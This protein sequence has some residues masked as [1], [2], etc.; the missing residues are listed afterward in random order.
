MTLATVYPLPTRSN[1]LL[2]GFIAAFLLAVVPEVA[3]AQY[4]S[5]QTPS[6][7]GEVAPYAMKAGKSANADQVLQLDDGSAENAIGFNDDTNNDGTSDQSLG[8]LYFNRF[9]PPAGDFP[10]ELHDVQI[11]FGVLDENG[12][13][14]PGGLS[15]GDVIDIYVWSDADGDPTTGATIEA[16]L[17][18]QALG[19]VDATFQTF[20]FPS[21]VR[22]NSPGNVLIG[23]TGRWPSKVFYPALLISPESF[24]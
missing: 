4:I 16:V 10:L 24:S 18:G 6:R 8:A 9:T 12:D 19:A 7:V 3:Q 23:S 22:I 2:V 14:D 11:Q 13:P 5:S 20:A 15:A 1:T 21:A 17:T